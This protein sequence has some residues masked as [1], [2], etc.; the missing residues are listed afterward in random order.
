MTEKKIKADEPL[1]DQLQNQLKKR[2]F[3]FHKS[4]KNFYDNYNSAYRSI[5]SYED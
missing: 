4:G 3:S 2:L 5:A 1:D